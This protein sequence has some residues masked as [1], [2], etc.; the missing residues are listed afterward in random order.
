MKTSALFL[1]LAVGVP[2]LAATPPTTADTL[3][4]YVEA[5]N[6]GDAELV[7]TTIPN[8]D[9]TAWMQKNVPR[10]ECPDAAIEETYYFRWWTLRKHLRATPEGFVV[11]EFLPKVSWSAKH[12]TISCAAGHHF[13]EGRWIHDPRYLDDYATFWFRRGGK[14]RQY[15]FWAADALSARYLVDGRAE[16]VLALLPDLGAN[17]AAWEKSNRDANGLFWQIDDRDGMEVSI[18][19]SGYRATINSYLYGEAIALARLSELAGKAEDATAFRAKAAQLKQLVQAKLWDADAKFFKVLPRGENT[20][21][22]DVR[23]LH[24]YTPW[25]FNLPDA[26]Y[27]EAWKQLADP[28]GFQAPFGPTTA[29][30]RHPRFAL[31]YQGHECQWNGPSWPYATAVTLTALANLLNRPEPQTAVTKADYFA[32]LKTYAASHRLKREDGKVVPWIDENLNPQTGDW[33]S[34]TRLK[35]WKNGTWDAGKGGVE[36]G[37]DYNHSTFC[38]L[39]IT[40][41]VGLR[42]RADAQVEVNPLA[43]E[44]WDYFCLE[45]VA[46]HGHQ[47]AIYYDK[48]GTRYGR[49]QGLRIFADGQEIAKSARLDRVAGSLP[50]LPASR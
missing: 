33:I 30:Q 50:A 10:F 12:N 14:P 8:K 2:A 37:K 45:N 39:V 42:P 26:P 46:Y 1:A 48:T 15:S 31:S 21:L 18:G 23:E 29:E 17:F 13:Y 43:P 44:A 25:Y 4:R 16:P 3:T 34:R 47:L 24:G 6:Q 49:G 20:K 28:Q 40:G 27:A 11:T 5:F 36:R 32:A 7:E 19:G 22:A 9:A 38:D 41:L 35:T